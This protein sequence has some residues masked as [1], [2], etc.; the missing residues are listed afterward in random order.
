MNLVNSDNVYSSALALPPESRAVL[1]DLLMESLTD[2]TRS[3]KLDPV[4]RWR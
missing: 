2:E 1:A 4:Q 3:G